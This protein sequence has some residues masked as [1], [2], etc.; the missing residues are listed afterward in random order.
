MDKQTSIKVTDRKP[1][2]IT[3]YLPPSA[4]KTAKDWEASHHMP[5]FTWAM[6]HSIGSTC[7]NCGG[8]G[9][10]YLRL[11]ERGPYSTQAA[12][13][14]LITWFDGD[15]RYRKGWYIVKDTLAFACPECVK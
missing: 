5:T 13:K 2:Y 15:E 4:M 10:V 12:G 6:D 8:G 1:Q 9:V 7:K 14:Q 3:P 11:M